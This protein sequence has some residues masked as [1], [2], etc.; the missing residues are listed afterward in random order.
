MSKTQ[1]KTTEDVPA[2]ETQAVADADG[3]AA[4]IVKNAELERATADVVLGTP[5]ATEEE[6]VQDFIVWL[7]EKAEEGN[8]DTMAM[9]AQ[10]LRQ[11][12]GAQSVREALKEPA[13]ASSKDVLDRPFLALSF[14]IHEGQYEDS[15]LPFFASIEA[16]F[17]EIEEPVILNTGAFKV[18]AVLRA[19]E[20]LNEWPLPMVF[21]G[22]NT[23]RGR[24]VVS[25]KY[26][27]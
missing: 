10:A 8:A 23:K 27:G 22:K 4:D 21:T 2:W 16:K 12:D 11:A 7:Q 6:M 3:E 13:T 18:L 1:S 25:L 14:T 5:E 17:Q 26:L 9:L 24:T 20:R 19:L 15:D